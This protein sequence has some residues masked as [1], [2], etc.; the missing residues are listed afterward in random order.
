MR[1]HGSHWNGWPL[2][3]GEPTLGDHLN[4]IGVRNVLVG[5][6]DACRIAAA[7]FGPI[8]FNLLERANIFIIGALRTCVL[9]GVHAQRH[10]DSERQQES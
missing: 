2:R 10:N 7:V 9:D 8:N 1:S 6:L 3:V 5:K 4:K